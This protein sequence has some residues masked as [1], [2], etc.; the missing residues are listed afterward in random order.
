MCEDRPGDVELRRPPHARI[1]ERAPQPGLLRRA[2]WGGLE[3]RRARAAF[4]SRCLRATHSPCREQHCV[5]KA[6]F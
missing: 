6:P 2:R 3:V 1:R 4:S 5:I